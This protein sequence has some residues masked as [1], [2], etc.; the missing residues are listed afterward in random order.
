MLA[1]YSSR[2]LSVVLTLLVGYLVGQ[3]PG[4]V[5]AAVMAS[6]EIGTPASATGHTPEGGADSTDDELEARARALL[7]SS[8]ERVL[9]TGGP[10]MNSIDQA[11]QLGSDYLKG[12]RTGEAFAWLQYADSLARGQNEE[13]R[14]QLV[15]A[16]ALWVQK[17][18]ASGVEPVLFF[19][20]NQEQRSDLSLGL[21]LLGGAALIF[22]L[23]LIAWRLAGRLDQNP[24]PTRTP[25]AVSPVHFFAVVLGLLSWGAGYGIDPSSRANVVTRTVGEVKSGPGESYMT[26]SSLSPGVILEQLSQRGQMRAPPH[27]A[28]VQVQFN[29]DEKGWVRA[30]NVLFLSNSV[31]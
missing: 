20:L 16:K 29:E 26:L 25:F 7:N 18:G 14:T 15:K 4:G 9:D 21:Q 5:V 28:W 31:R 30:E 2:F 10:F 13:L 3:P 8:E 22:A 24:E 19:G 27:E 1:N 17:L 11:H 6:T 23:G 12:G